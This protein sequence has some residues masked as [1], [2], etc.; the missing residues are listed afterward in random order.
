MD[1]SSLPQ[2]RGQDQD[3]PVGEHDLS[4]KTSLGAGFV[5]VVA[6]VLALVAGTVLA[7]WVIVRLVAAPAG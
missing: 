5:L 2:Y 6:A 3:S 4:D 1:Y 7:S